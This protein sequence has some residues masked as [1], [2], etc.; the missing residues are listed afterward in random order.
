MIPL[1]SE[2][3]T[4]DVLNGL[5]R[6][7]RDIAVWW[8]TW[9]EC[10]VAISRLEREGN[11]DAA[12]A[13]EARAALEALAETWAEVRPTDDIRLTASLLSQN[14]PLKAADALQLAAALRWCEGEPADHGFCCLDRRLRRVAVD[15]GFR[16][17]PEGMEL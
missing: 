17:L 15:E 1:V 9:P 11:L 2:E 5:L 16:V 7:D 3:T 8:G 10:A 14:H 6:E 12:S 4:S 13:S